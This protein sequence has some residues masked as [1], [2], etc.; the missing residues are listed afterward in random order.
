MATNRVL[1]KSA[2]NIYTF[3]SSVKEIIKNI[4]ITPTPNVPEY[5]IGTTTHREE[6]VPVLN[7]E[8]ILYDENIK[9]NRNREKIYISTENSDNSFIFQVEELIG[10][11]NYENDFQELIMPFDDIFYDKAL[12]YDDIPVIQINYAKFLKIITQEPTLKI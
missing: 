5:F 12:L 9:E 3:D 8:L 2:G 1:F 10:T 4:S 7:F 6:I 11:I